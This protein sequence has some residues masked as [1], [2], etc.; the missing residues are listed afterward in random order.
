MRTID[1]KLHEKRKKQI[2]DAATRCFIR[3]GFHQTSMKEICHEAGM[4][5]GNL[6]RYFKGKDEIIQAATDEEVEWY[7]DQIKKYISSKNIVKVLTKMAMKIIKVYNDPEQA[8]LVAEV[9][10]EA[11]RNVSIKSC[12]F[13]N[14]RQITDEITSL[15][16]RAIKDGDISPVLKAE[17]I[18]EA[19]MALI[20]GY[21]TRILVNP[22]FKPKA[23]EKIIKLM[24]ESL[25]QPT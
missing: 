7:L 25:L 16:H 21:S 9:Y 13:K 23:F 8:C 6:Y 24:I 2:V 1:L 19:F 15:L 4:S 14:N 18:A 17:Q 5:P 20:D 10:A 11:A 3:R 12:L 22:D